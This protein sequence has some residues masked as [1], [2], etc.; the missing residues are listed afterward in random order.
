MYLTHNHCSIVHFIWHL[1][2]SQRLH[3][4]NSVP[5]IPSLHTP[6]GKTTSCPKSP[7]TLPKKVTHLQPIIPE[8][9][10]RKHS[11]STT[12]KSIS[13]S[14]LSLTSSISFLSSS[15][16]F[17]STA[18]S[19]T[20]NS[21]TTKVKGRKKPAGKST[22]LKK[23]PPKQTAVRSSSKDSMELKL[24]SG[25][26]SKTKPTQQ[27]R[28]LSFSSNNGNK[29]MSGSLKSIHRA[30]ET[31]KAKKAKLIACA[32]R[33]KAKMVDEPRNEAGLTVDEILI[34]VAKMGKLAQ[35]SKSKSPKFKP[36][37]NQ[38]PTGDQTTKQKKISVTPKSK[39]SQKPPMPTKGTPK[40][41]PTKISKSPKETLSTPSTLEVQQEPNSSRASQA[42]GCVH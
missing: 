35:R 23:S 37:T 17:S 32:V 31:L 29:K 38:S 5:P 15:D 25:R 13:I 4:N 2:S 42:G 36:Q 41:T 21:P 22:N 34:S 7:R 28:K 39:N 33:K 9:R 11:R 8:Q 16:S 12:P 24:K 14:P 40:L 10:A 19:P 20:Q 30:K 6:S 18:W 26:A 27:K 1:L 3:S